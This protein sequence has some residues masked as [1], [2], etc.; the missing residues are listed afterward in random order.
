MSEFILVASLCLM[1]SGVLIFGVCKNAAGHIN[2]AVMLSGV[3]GDLGFNYMVNIA[4][5]NTERQLNLRGTLL[6]ENIL[7]ENTVDTVEGLVKKNYQ[8]II[9]SSF[10]HTGG[11]YKMA[12]KYKNVNFLLRDIPCQKVGDGSCNNLPSNVGTIMMDLGFPQ[13]IIGYIAGLVSKNHSVGIVVPGL[14]TFSYSTAN[15]FMIGVTKAVADY[16][17]P[18][19]KVYTVE[20]GSWLDVDRE[21]GATQK[22]IDLNV[23]VIGMSS[24]DLTV[25]QVAIENGA[26]TFGTSGY[27]V[28]NVLGESILTSVL[29]D[30]TATFINAT[31][32]VM[33]GN[34][35]SYSWQGEYSTGDLTMDIYS[36]IVDNVTMS[37]I[38]QELT[39][40]R[41]S[42]NQTI[43]P[44]NCHILYKQ[45]GYPVDSNNC[46]PYQSLLDSPTLL[47]GIEGLGLYEI[48]V[49]HKPIG[50]SIT[51]G[52][53]ITTGIVAFVAVLMLLGVIIFKSTK[54][55]KSA[56]PVFCMAIIVG[57]LLVFSGIIIWVQEP[58][59]SLCRARYCNPRLKR[60]KITNKTLLPYIL[61]L[62]I[63]NC[64]I[65]AVMTG[66]GKIESIRS[67]GTD[68]LSTY[69]YRNMCDQK[70]SGNI[71]LYILLGY[72]G[73]MLLVGCFVSWKI[74]I[75]E[76]P[77][78]NE[79]KPIANTL[80]AISFCL[81]IIIPLI[82]SQNGLD[83]QVI[84]ICA[85]ALFT[86][87]SSLVILFVPK[88]WRLYTKG[89][90]ADP[91]SSSSTNTFVAS[92]GKSNAVGMQTVVAAGMDETNTSA[93]P[94]IKDDSESISKS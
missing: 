93:P 92:V 90:N 66:I 75:V 67:F 55:L 19:S 72:H 91:F 86:T 85:S 82:V 38:Q 18:A 89:V 63:L 30:W 23:D 5:V 52:F 78:F 80:Y 83:S 49:V 12:A 3:V 51:L 87:A 64:I 47:K 61:A 10:D 62:I 14:P 33:N 40:I 73:I 21:R 74:R 41:T 36:H 53:S 7:T 69:Q 44:Y 42:V 71:V 8:L 56:S 26:Y 25:Q 88:F 81:F 15:A 58:D 57:G 6:L 28:F 24:D 31:R 46:V 1:S 34:W 35:S 16:G 43:Q 50:R 54:I 45:S 9:C 32:M 77:E 94:E 70:L 22:L 17:L 29:T 65:L 79:S 76:I 13:Y 60:L 27:P 84:V 4:R 2:L 11:C 59:T 20:T 68:G 37:R 39:N 48:P